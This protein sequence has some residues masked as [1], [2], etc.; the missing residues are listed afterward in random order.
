MKSLGLMCSSEC[1][2]LAPSGMNFACLLVLS[3]QDH[4]CFD[5]YMRFVDLPYVRDIYFMIQKLMFSFAV[6]GANSRWQ[7]RLVW[8]GLHELV[9]I[10]LPML[11]KVKDY[12]T[13]YSLGTMKYSKLYISCLV[14]FFILMAWVS[15]C[16]VNIW[17]ATC[18]CIV[19]YWIAN[20]LLMLL[21]VYFLYINKTSLQTPCYWL[22]SSKGN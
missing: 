1:I 21:L 11:L 6:Y 10:I 8:F 17:T 3:S 22:F 4:D 2:H 15:L 18:Y 12:R 7:R 14:Y 9:G 13:G 16:S 19:E 20:A 5:V